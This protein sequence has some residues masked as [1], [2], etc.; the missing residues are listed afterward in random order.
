MD[1]SGLIFRSSYLGDTLC[2][3]SFPILLYGSD[4]LAPV[5]LLGPLA[6]YVFLRY[7]SGDKENEASQEERYARDYPAKKDELEVY[8]NEKNSFW[9][10]VQEINNQW[11]WVVVG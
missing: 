5:E 11:T 2:H 1:L 10:S 9:P 4:M 7:F 6:N 3:L 8:R